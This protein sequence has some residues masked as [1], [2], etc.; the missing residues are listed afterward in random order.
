MTSW[1]G[2]QQILIYQYLNKAPNTCLNLI[3]KYKYLNTKYVRGVI[4]YFK[5]Q[6]STSKYQHKVRSTNIVACKNN[7]Q[8]YISMYKDQTS[9]RKV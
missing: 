9:V 2:L 8:L 5:Y 4:L 3:F 6:K 7:D 1:S